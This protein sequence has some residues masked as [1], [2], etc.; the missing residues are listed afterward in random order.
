MERRAHLISTS[1][2]RVGMKSNVHNVEADSP[3]WLLGARSLFVMKVLA[4]DERAEG[5]R[6]GRTLGSPLEPGDE[7]VLHLREVLNAYCTVHENVG[8]SLVGAEAPQLLRLRGLPPKLA[9]QH[10]RPNF[11]VVP[12]S[13]FSF[14]NHSRELLSKRIRGR[15]YAVV[16]V[17]RFRERA[18]G[19]G[20]EDRLA[21]VDDRFRDLEGHAGVC[22]L[23]V[24]EADLEMKLA[25]SRNDV[26][27][28][29][30]DGREDARVRF[31]ETLEAFDELREV[32][33]L[34][35]LD[36]ISWKD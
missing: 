34:L 28:C 27:A 7:R 11:R 33:L 29:F 19:R 36:L 4:F 13:N 6:G 24:G 12:R 25:G 9:A 30:G 2:D 26:L 15:P 8:S 1:M 22:I 20:A 14:F 21:E 18:R 35:D 16:T 3:H 17:R 5:E 10:G 32:A 23:E 31:R